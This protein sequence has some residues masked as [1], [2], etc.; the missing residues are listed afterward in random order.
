MTRSR[1]ARAAWWLVVLPAVLAVEPPAALAGPAALTAS[2]AAGKSEVRTDYL[3]IFM[4]GKKVGYLCHTRA[5]AGG[6][7]TTI[8]VSSISLSRTGTPLTMRTREMYVETI[9]GR[10]LSFS[11]LQDLALARQKITGTVD[12]AGNLTI[13]ITAGGQTRTRT[14]PWPKGALMPEAL[15]RLQQQKGLAEGTRYKAKAFSPTFMR[16]IDMEVVVGPTKEVDLLGRVVR[17]TEVKVTMSTPNG[18]IDTIN[19]VDSQCDA[20]KTITSMMGLKMELIS[21]SKQFA[22]SPNDTLE[23]FERVMLKSPQPLKGLRQAKSATYHLVPKGDAE[24]VFLSSD[25]QIV[26]RGKGEVTVTVRLVQPPRNVP[27]PYKGAEKISLEALKSTQFIQCDDARVKA[28]AQR[29]VRGAADALDAARR[30]ESFVRSYIKTKN[31]SVGYASA[32]EVALS[33][34]GDC[35]EHAVLTAAM[36]RAVGIPA[37]VVSGLAYVEQYAGRSDIFAPHAWTR[38]RLAGK[39]IDLDSAMDGFDAGHIAMV[40]GD[41]NLDEFFGMISTL[42]NFKITKVEVER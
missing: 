12:D 32:A 14:M 8:E 16:A 1:N 22:L 9:D 2:K 31:L 30:I 4:A 28:L 39:W 3:A 27:F 18:K 40:A 29:A 42:G 17:L 26:R 24:L 36:C 25:S 20:L 10:P 13:T 11:S 7:V 6:K 41:G 5:V 23:F 34:R 35:T 15:R 38:V 21:C 37:Q 33:R 19:Y